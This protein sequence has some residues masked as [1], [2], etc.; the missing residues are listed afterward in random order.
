MP[1]A[2]NKWPRVGFEP[3]FQY[4]SS[5]THLNI[6]LGSSS[7]CRDYHD[8][9]M[10]RYRAAMAEWDNFDVAAWSVRL[11]QSLKLSYSATYF[12]LASEEARGIGSLAAAYFL[13][14]YSAL[15]A[16]WSVL[17]LHPEQGHDAV[18]DITHSKLKKVFHSAFAGGNGKI[19][20][21]DA[22]AL[23]DDLRFLRPSIRRTC[24]RAV[25]FSSGV[26]T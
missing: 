3:F 6:N 18:A 16:M 25:S 14:Y 2:S 4:G 23:V 9:W 1:V 12:A 8:H 13:A 21:V 19:L 10:R 20:R 17:F 7:A 26:A 5:F 11:R 15:H 22:S 24:R